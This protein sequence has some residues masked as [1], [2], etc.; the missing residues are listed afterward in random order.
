MRCS[1]AMTALRVTPLAEEEG[2][3]ME[4]TEEVGGVAICVW[5]R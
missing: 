1:C 2:V 3:D 5:A 4:G